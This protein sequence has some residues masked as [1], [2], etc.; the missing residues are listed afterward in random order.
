MVVSVLDVLEENMRKPSF[1]L[2]WV[3]SESLSNSIRYP[4]HFYLT[5]RRRYARLNLPLVRK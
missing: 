1:F 5:V 2:D 3:L 4:T